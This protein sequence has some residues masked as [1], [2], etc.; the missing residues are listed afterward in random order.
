MTVEKYM[1]IAIITGASSGM[2]RE[3]VLQLDKIAHLDE[4]WVIARDEE[5]LKRLNQDTKATK[6][7]IP[8]DLEGEEAYIYFEKLLEE[9]K[10]T[11]RVL[12]NSAGFGL[13]G[14]VSEL[15][16]CKQTAMINLNCM[17]LTR[18]TL[19][20]LP[21]MQKG[22][23]IIQLA[24]ASAFIPQ[25]GFAIYAATKAYVLSYTRALNAELADKQIYATA[26]CPGPVDT[27]FFEVS[28]K[29]GKPEGI[30]RFFLS[31]AKKV[32]SHALK[33]SVCKKDIAVYGISMQLLYI[34]TH[35]PFEK[36]LVELMAKYTD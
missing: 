31:D 14:R 15:D 32:V 24:S 22:S 16:A 3:F 27:P 29:T 30:K 7:I 9:T 34:A 21:Y 20:C 12:V 4:I 10:P 8:L 13:S 26:V 6:K 18:M 2:G 11:I 19:L 1:N 5:K 25:P 35:V 36:K 28:S 17:A 33:K 23:R